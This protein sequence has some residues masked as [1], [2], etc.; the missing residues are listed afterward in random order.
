MHV[1]RYSL[2]TEINRLAHFSVTAQSVCKLHL[3]RRAAFRREKPGA[4]YHYASAARPRRGDIEAIEIVQKFH[5]ARRVFRR[6]GGHGVDNQGRF[7]P[8]KP[9]DRSHPCAGAADP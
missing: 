7:L 1:P 2:S 9:V 5:P 3:P 8:L 6:R 4:A